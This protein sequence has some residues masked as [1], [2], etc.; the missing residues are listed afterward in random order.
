MAS[1]STARLDN[2]KLLD[3]ILGSPT[4]NFENKIKKETAPVVNGFKAPAKAKLPEK[5]NKRYK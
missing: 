3:H 1:E 5:E 4:A 2:V